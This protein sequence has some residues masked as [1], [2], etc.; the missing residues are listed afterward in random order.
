M[1]VT[2]KL[3]FSSTVVEQAIDEGFFFWES[4]STGS[5]VEDSGD[6]DD[7]RTDRYQL[8]RGHLRSNS[9]RK[10]AAAPF[11]LSPQADVRA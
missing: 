5:I 8:F 3:F 9:R 11:L 1:A 4:K 10:P 7:N 6:E 2:Y